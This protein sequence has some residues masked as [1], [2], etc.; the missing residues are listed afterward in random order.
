VAKLRFG[1]L[2][3]KAPDITGTIM[4]MVAQYESARDRNILLAWETP[5][6]E[7]EGGEVTDDRLLKHFDQRISESAPG[8]PM[9]DYWEET[10]AQYQFA[11][12]EDKM[13]TS[14]ELGKIK[15]GAMATF[16]RHWAKKV[17][18]DSAAWRSL[19]Q[20]AGR[21]EQATRA[22]AGASSRSNKVEMYN[23]DMER[24]NKTSIE[25]G[26]K[27]WT[28]L[29]N[30][31][32]ALN[33]PIDASTGG[34]GLDNTANIDDILAST[35]ANAPDDYRQLQAAMNVAYPGRT[36]GAPLT[37][38]DIQRG[39]SKMADGLRAQ[40]RRT[41][42]AGYSTSSLEG[43][44]G[45]VKANVINL[46]VARSDLAD[47]YR[48]AQEEYRKDMEAAAGHPD[49][50]VRANEAFAEA[51]GPLVKKADR[52]GAITIAGRIYD[53]QRAARG[54]KPRGNVSAAKD[55]AGPA[56]TGGEE[57]VKPEEAVDAAE[58]GVFT[59]LTDL[60]ATAA[61]ALQSKRTLEG[62]AKGELAQY[63]DAENGR[64]A[65]MPVDELPPGWQTR[66][67]RVGNTITR[68]GDGNAVG[69][70]GGYAIQAAAPKPVKSVVGNRNAA[71][72]VIDPTATVTTDTLYYQLQWSD[73][74]T[75][76]MTTIATGRTDANG[77]PIV[78]EVFTDD[79]IMHPGL[80][81]KVPDL[82]DD[83]SGGFVM[84]YTPED[85]QAI[86]Q[87]LVI[88]SQFNSSALLTGEGGTV[89]DMLSGERVTSRAGVAA[90]GGVT[91]T[92]LDEKGRPVQTTTYKLAQD[93]GS[94]ETKGGA[95]DPYA[96]MRDEQGNLIPLRGVSAGEDTTSEEW[97][98]M[99][100]NIYG[101]VA[102]ERSQYK[103]ETPTTEERMRASGIPIP[104]GWTEPAPTPE[105]PPAGG[106]TVPTAPAGGAATP[107]VPDINDPR[108][109][110]PLGGRLGT[111]FVLDYAAVRA[112]KQPDLTLVNNW[113]SSTLEAAARSQRAAQEFAQSD[114]AKVFEI[115]LARN[116]KLASDP[117]LQRQWFV[118][119]DT[120]RASQNW[121]GSEGQY[122]GAVIAR[123]PMMQGNGFFAGAM[124]SMGQDIAD[125]MF[126][127]T[128]PAQQQAAL[129]GLLGPEAQR[130]AEF[131]FRALAR[132]NRAGVGEEIVGAAAQGLGAPIAS[133]AGGPGGTGGEG[134]RLPPGW[135]WMTGDQR[136]HW[137]LFQSYERDRRDR[138]GI[139]PDTGDIVI[140][141]GTTG[142]TGTPPPVGGAAPV[143][144]TRP[145]G[146]IW[147]SP[148]GGSAF[149]KPV[150]IR[151]GVKPKPVVTPTPRPDKPPDTK[152]DRPD[153]KT[154]AAKT[155]IDAAVGA[156]AGGLS[157]PKTNYGYTGSTWGH[158]NYTTPKAG[159]RS[160]F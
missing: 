114:M 14:Y 38:L 24:I 48:D 22:A 111:S 124:R 32:A 158:D 147:G 134:T 122:Q 7:F 64:F 115:D 37:A 125:K 84:F 45:R 135:G 136:N 65:Y 27:A 149:Q 154:P 157:L 33:I 145:A 47:Q 106:E 31:A 123:N 67:V 35:A 9:R 119:A 128:L 141:E 15:E 131:Q 153:V 86:N 72:V 36:N 34:M 59:D 92:E 42:R 88:G 101:S 76:K 97:F 41:R 39:M 19:M 2:P 63:W 156:A 96:F 60:E 25:P 57:T 103:G 81:G 155:A 69:I 89:I 100:K 30:A 4:A 68:D 138:E 137:L 18:R 8:D 139:D 79:E 113:G 12:A 117:E 23:R 51:L 73:D 143:L 118:G 146:T 150:N 10:K 56:S 3:T 26:M 43:Q 110:G 87:S 112:L 152:P 44:L 11:I 126:A 61:H 50:E 159:R 104:E 93:V 140:P 53:Q 80:D 133:I 144:P 95:R 66:T 13:K 49:L 17:P 151:G 148:T 85:V 6:A 70:A 28:Y 74:E 62:Y 109:A 142:P 16:Y 52:L 55:W 107:G 83:G 46:K 105:T 120:I 94:G 40:I 130:Q 102:I 1:R 75:T 78:T 71:G 91:T 77:N 121:Q 99:A 58:K 129:S 54:E 132:A 90:E 21:F 108:Y 160:G 20:S 29:V 98:R 82:I 5:E 116:P 127:R